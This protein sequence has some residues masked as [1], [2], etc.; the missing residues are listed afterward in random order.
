MRRL[1]RGS[2]L[3]LLPNSVGL[4]LLIA[5]SACDLTVAQGQESTAEIRVQDYYPGYHLLRMSERDPDTRAFLLKHFKGSDPSIIRADFDGNGQPDYAM[6]L[7]GDTSAA[8]KLVVLLCDAPGRCR[9]VYEVDITGYSDEAYL[10]RLPIGS[11]VAVAGSVEGEQPPPVKL[12]AVGI[13]VTYFEKGQ[14]A[15]YWDKKLKKI[16]EVGTGE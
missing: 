1:R 15:L 14:V 9:R 4:L 7:K 11:R 5:A 12:T 16:V 10:S 2:Y 13:Q 8:A 3:R 6:L